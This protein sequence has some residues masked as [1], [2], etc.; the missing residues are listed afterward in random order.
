MLTYG[1]AVSNININNLVKFHKEQDT[2]GTVTGVYPA[3]RFGD[4]KAKGEKVTSFKEKASV[5]AD[6]RMINGGFFVF[7]KEFLD[8]IPSD[9]D[10]DLERKPLEELVERNEL[11]VY[12][13]KE[14]WQCMDTYRDHQYLNKLYSD[15]AAWKIWNE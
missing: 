7:K 6:E 2:I 15:G 1:D 3:S 5:I 4:L 9:P 14:F 11:S 10:T 12:R 13:H 8:T